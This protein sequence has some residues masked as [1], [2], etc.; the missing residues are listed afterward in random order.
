[1]KDLRDFIALL[2]DKGQLTVIDALVDPVLEMTEIADRVVKAGGPALLFTNPKGC[3]TPVLMNQFGSDERICLALGA[4]S[5]EQLSERVAE[6]T[7][8]DVPDTTW[9]KLKALGRLKAIADLQPGV[10]KRG[11]CQEV[12]LTR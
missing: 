10:V 12:V 9:D 5:Y 1:M 7:A 4:D 6:L 2:R 8:I 11:A 3:S